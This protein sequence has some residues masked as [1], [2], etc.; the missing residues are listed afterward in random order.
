MPD[1]LQPD[2]RELKKVLKNLRHPDILGHS[3]LIGLRC[4]T[5]EVERIQIADSQMNRAFTLIKL[6][7]DTIVDAIR[8]QW[9]RS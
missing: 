8:A 4:V 3:T 2:L 9:F 1:R 7:E 6:I 5:R